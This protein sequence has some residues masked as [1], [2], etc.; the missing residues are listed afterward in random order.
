MAA[1]A[2]AA[3]FSSSTLTIFAY[4]HPVLV[5]SALLTKL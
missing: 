4:P 5:H 1:M 2:T 3:V